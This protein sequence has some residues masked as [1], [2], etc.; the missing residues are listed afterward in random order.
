MTVC[1]C[2]YLC[3]GDTEWIPTRKDS[4]DLSSFCWQGRVLHS[5]SWDV[6]LSLIIVT[7]YH[8]S[9]CRILLSQNLNP[10]SPSE[11]SSSLSPINTI[12][13]PTSDWRTPDQT[14]GLLCLWTGWLSCDHTVCNTSWMRECSYQEH[15]DTAPAC[16]WRLT[17]VCWLIN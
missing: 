10:K 2:V 15:R 8:R 9:N 13:L 1:T 5:C 6:R 3:W 16:L 11:K 4:V 14:S 12:S 17:P 7:L